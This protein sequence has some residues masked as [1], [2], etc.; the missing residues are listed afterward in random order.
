HQAYIQSGKVSVLN[1]AD[2]VA[3]YAFMAGAVGAIWGC[4]NYM[5]RECVRLW[6][7]CAAKDYEQALVLWQK[8]LPSIIWMWS[9]EYISA[10]KNAVRIRGYEGGAVR[11]PL[12]PI[13]N[14]DEQ[15][16]IVALACLDQ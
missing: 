10:I 4:A 5:P 16:L 14:E 8:M 3:I 12:R 2:P 7:L 13:S 9:N 1:G 6:A 15:A 11:K